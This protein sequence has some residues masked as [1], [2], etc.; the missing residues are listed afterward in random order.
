VRLFFDEQLSEDLS[1]LLHD[2]FSNSLHARALLDLKLPPADID[3]INVLSAKAQEETLTADETREL[4]SY[5]NVG[6]TLELIKAKARLS[7]QRMKP[8]V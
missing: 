5:L 6:R 8:P 1:K 3:R 2:I 4:G 7:L